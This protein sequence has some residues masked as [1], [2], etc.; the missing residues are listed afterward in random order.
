MV[1]NDLAVIKLNKRIERSTTIDWICLPTIV[2]VHDQ[3]LLRVVSYGLTNEQL[4]QQQ[5]IVRVLQ[6]HIE[7]QRQISDIAQDAFCTR[8]TSSTGV[9]GMVR[10]LIC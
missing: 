4:V 10:Q 6:N 8:S 5:L 9:L 7:C 3:D 2:N 1:K